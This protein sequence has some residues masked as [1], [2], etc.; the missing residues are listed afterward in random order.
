MVAQTV[1]KYRTETK[2]RKA[3]VNV[4]VPVGAEPDAGVTVAVS[5]TESAAVLGE[6]LVTTAVDVE[7]LFTTCE[8]VEL[9][10]A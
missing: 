1:T 9:T 10:L 8:I 3:S 4:T 5:V 6:P 2:T 7:M